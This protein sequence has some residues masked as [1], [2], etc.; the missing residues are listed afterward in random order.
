MPEFHGLANLGGVGNF[1]DGNIEMEGLT[2]ECSVGGDGLAVGVG[3]DAAVLS[4]LFQ[5]GFFNF[6]QNQGV[7]GGSLVGDVGTTVYAVFPLVG[8]GSLAAG[9]FHGEVG[10]VVFIAEPVLRLLGDLHLIGVGIDLVGGLF[11][12]KILFF[13]IPVLDDFDEDLTTHGLFGHGEGVG[14]GVQT[15]NTGVGS[16]AGISVGVSA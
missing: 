11:Q 2:Q 6:F 4:A 15:G 16:C 5:D 1:V 8:V 14:I 7:R 3:D 12:L 13:Q 9:N 10:E